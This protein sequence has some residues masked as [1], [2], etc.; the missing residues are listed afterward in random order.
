M[1]LIITFFDSGTLHSEVLAVALWQR[2]LATH[3]SS[4]KIYLVGAKKGV[5]FLLKSNLGS[6]QEIVYKS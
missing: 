3:Q 5:H 6:S 1:N 4:D 2:V